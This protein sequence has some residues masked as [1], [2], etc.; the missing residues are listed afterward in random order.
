M[1][2]ETGARSAGSQITAAQRDRHHRT[3]PVRLSLSLRRL[4][5]EHFDA[6]VLY[7]LAWL[8][9]HESPGMI[10]R[11]NLSDASIGELADLLTAGRKPTIGW[12]SRHAA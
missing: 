1:T 2:R 10:A 4:L 3:P 11:R 7:E 9:Q 8:K 6:A 5:I 12:W